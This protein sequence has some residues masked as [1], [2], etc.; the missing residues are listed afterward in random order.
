MVSQS[1]S[2]SVSHSTQ[3]IFSPSDAPLSRLAT[4]LVYWHTN[5]QTNKQLLAAALP[6]TNAHFVILQADALTRGQACSTRRYSNTRLCCTRP[7]HDN[8]NKH[9]NFHNFIRKNVTLF[10]SHHNTNIYH[11]SNAVSQR[12]MVWLVNHE[13]ERL[14]LCWEVMLRVTWLLKDGGNAF[15]R[16]ADTL[17]LPS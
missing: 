17:P 9:P 2:Q 11:C 12:Y 10:T 13:P 6:H 16:K 8:E 7:Y 4:S 15:L 14:L 1:V 3:A 5:K